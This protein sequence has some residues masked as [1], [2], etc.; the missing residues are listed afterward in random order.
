MRALFAWHAD[1][2]L[3]NRTDG[4]PHVMPVWF[5]LDGTNV[6][7]T[8][9]AASVKGRNLRREGRACLCVDDQ[10]PLYSF[11]MIEATAAISEGLEALGEWATR[12]TVRYTGAERGAEFGAPTRSRARS[13]SASPSRTCSRR[14]TPPPERL[15]PASWRR[16]RRAARLRDAHADDARH[17]GTARPR[18]AR[19]DPRAARGR[20]RDA[21]LPSAVELDHRPELCTAGGILHGGRADGAG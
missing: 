7:L 20:E 15:P 16:A 6:V 9:G 18:P 1:R 11:V 8:T 4:R 10:A 21:G 5:V 13:S 3:A 19:R 12:I 17:R 14:P 2:Q